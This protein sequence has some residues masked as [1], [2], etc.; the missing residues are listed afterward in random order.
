MKIAGRR[1]RLCNRPPSFIPNLLA[2]MVERKTQLAR[3]EALLKKN[4]RISRNQTI[5][6]F[7]YRL[8]ARIADLEERGWVF[9]TKWVKG[10]YVYAVSKRPEGA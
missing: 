5:R 10:D 1:E 7:I 3:I 6:M 4:R 8:S 2:F 9:R